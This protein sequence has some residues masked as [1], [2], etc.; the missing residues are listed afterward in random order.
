LLVRNGEENTAGLL[1]TSLQ[2]RWEEMV[3]GST[4]NRS[5]R[6]CRTVDVLVVANE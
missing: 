5:L 2:N 1:H 4:V 6:L 3:R